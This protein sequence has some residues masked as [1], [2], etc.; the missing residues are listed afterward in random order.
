MAPIA[1]LGPTES[2]APLVIGLSLGSLTSPSTSASL[3]NRRTTYLL[4]FLRSHGRC[5][6]FGDIAVNMSGELDQFQG[7][8]ASTVRSKGELNATC[9]IR[10]SHSRNHVASSSLL[11][12]S[13]IM[14]TVVV[15]VAAVALIVLVIY[16]SG[17]YGAR[18]RSAGTSLRR[19]PSSHTTMT[20]RTKIGF[21]TRDEAAE[22]ARLMTRRDGAPMSVYQCATCAKW[23]VGHER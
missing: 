18:G 23:H 14:S 10:N 21:A 8:S 16:W 1:Q 13:T 11:V 12:E 17:R 6:S 15:L 2:I 19:G 9:P 7:V 5:S 20:G 4:A 22:R 3:I